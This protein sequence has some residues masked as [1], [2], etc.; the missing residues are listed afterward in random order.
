MASL[1]HKLILLGSASILIIACATTSAL[2]FEK[3]GKSKQS[4]ADAIAQIK[5]NPKWYGEKNKILYQFD[6]GALYHY[7]QNHDSATHYLNQAV[8]HYAQLYTKSVT[9]E[10]LS[11]LTNDNI[12]PY[13]AK[14]FEIT[15]AHTLLASSYMA[16]GNVDEALV[17]SRRAQLL[18]DG[19]S[20]KEKKEEI[21]TDDPWFHFVSALAYNAQGDKDNAAIS[22]YHSVKAYR[23]LGIGTPDAIAGAASVQFLETG[24]SDDLKTLGLSETAPTDIPKPTGEEIIVLGYAGKGPVLGERAFWATYVMDGLLVF[25]YR[26]SKGDTITEAISAPGLPQKE[27]DK[28]S[29]G[30]KTRS[31][32][33]YHL[34]FALPE[35]RSRPSNTQRFKASLGDGKAYTSSI[36][37]NTESMLNRYLEENK[38]SIMTRTVIRVV[39]RTIASQKTK[40]NLNTDNPLLN[41]VVNI[42]TD[43]LADQLEQADTR[44][45]FLLPKTI[46][47]IRIPVAPGE[48]QLNLAALNSGNQILNQAPF[49]IKVKKGEKKVLIYT[50]ME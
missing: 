32:T 50:S 23:E 33:T 16:Q 2:R 9:N 30:R 34:K 3:L 35:M 17:E 15:M 41:L 26:N 18:F 10:A 36:V 5:K 29:A 39:L 37:Y 1:H 13:R 7:D 31:G 14:P 43:I 25:H 22:M 19:W 45:W 20:K 27:Y 46:H 28:A 47:M 8:D 21:Y 11:I 49:T 24:R 40:A 6:L 38:T 12:R 42:G 44:N 4:N 48:F